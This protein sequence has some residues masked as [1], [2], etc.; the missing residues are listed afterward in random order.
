MLRISVN[1]EMRL[2]NHRSIGGWYMVVDWVDENVYDVVD[3]GF[4]EFVSWLW[5]I[6]VR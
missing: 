1:I 5:L 2:A 4:V 3:H 6:G